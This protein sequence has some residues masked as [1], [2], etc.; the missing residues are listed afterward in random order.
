MWLCVCV[1]LRAHVHPLY[2][3]K[4]VCEFIVEFVF[5][6]LCMNV[7]VF[8]AHLHESACLY[9]SV[10]TPLV[11]STHSERPVHYRW[12]ELVWTRGWT[13]ATKQS[14]RSVMLAH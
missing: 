7:S 14:L 4:C 5:T 6:L 11:V 13:L 2:V 1:C 9:L 8:F 10:L 12:C 3:Y